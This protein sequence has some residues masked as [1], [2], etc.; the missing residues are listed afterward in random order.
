MSTRIKEYEGSE[1][2]GTD[3]KYSQEARHTFKGIH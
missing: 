1:Y 3:E 2:D